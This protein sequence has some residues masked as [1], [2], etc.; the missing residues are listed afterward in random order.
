MEQ[1]RGL[2]FL[3]SHILV[4][5]NTDMVRR[6]Q[7]ELDSTLDRFRREYNARYRGGNFND[8]DR[9]LRKTFQPFYDIDFLFYCNPKMLSIKGRIRPKS[10]TRYDKN[11]SIRNLQQYDSYRNMLIE[12]EGF[13]KFDPMKQGQ[14][15]CY[16]AN[17]INR[18]PKR[19]KSLEI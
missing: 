13:I 8:E 4:N 1:K 16:R 3:L 7:D 17:A 19:Q 11:D 2:P 9:T 14:Q 10:N 6:C 5:K 18:I 12:K 15:P